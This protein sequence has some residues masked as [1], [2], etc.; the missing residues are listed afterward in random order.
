L[1]LFATSTSVSVSVANHFSNSQPRRCGD[2]FGRA[3]TV[4]PDGPPP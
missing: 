1:I 2:P 3:I 4:P